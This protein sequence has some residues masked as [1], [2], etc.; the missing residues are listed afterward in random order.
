MPGTMCRSWSEDHLWHNIHD[1]GF[2]FFIY[3]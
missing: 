3:L 1:D 2:F